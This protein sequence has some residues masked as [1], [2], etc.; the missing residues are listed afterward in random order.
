MT[1]APTTVPDDLTPGDTTPD[2]DLRP[3]GFFHSRRWLFGEMLVG[4][5]ISLFAAFVLST[6]AVNLARD[7]AASLAC[8]FSAIFSCSTVALSWQASLFGFPNAFLGLA[9]EPVVI[10]VAVLGLAGTRFPKWFMIAA[11]TIYLFGFVFAYWLFFEAVFTIHALC[12]W[13]LTVQLAT[14]VVFF[15][16]LH[17]NILENNLHWPPRVQRVAMSVVRSGGLGFLLAAWLI[18]TVAIVL[19]KYGGSLLG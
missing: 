6:E 18:A 17:L 1:T 2:G 11:Q 9:A 10:T 8:D 4:A 5:L 14:T 19:L 16:M 12:V 7:P 3:S 13:C 15:S